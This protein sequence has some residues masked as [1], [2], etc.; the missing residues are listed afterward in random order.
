MQAGR[1]RAIGPDILWGKPSG[2]RDLLAVIRWGLN[3]R[4]EFSRLLDW[5]VGGVTGRLPSPWRA[6]LLTKYLIGPLH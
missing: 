2:P 6:A 4:S 5:G 1:R 3:A